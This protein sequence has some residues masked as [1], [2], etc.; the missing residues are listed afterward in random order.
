MPDRTIIILAEA[1]EA[2]RESIEMI[3]T[4]EG[5]DCHTVRDYTSLLQAIPACKSDLI[6]VDINIIYADIEEFLSTLQQYSPHPPI[7]VTLTYERIGDMLDMVKFGVSEYLLKPFPFEEMVER[8][9]K[10]ITHKTNTNTK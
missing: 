3:L 2:I 4:D 1:E 5:Y 6:I 9:E 7:L 10:L 8:V